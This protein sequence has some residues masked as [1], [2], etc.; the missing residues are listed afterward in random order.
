MKKGGHTTEERERKSR[1]TW[2]GAWHLFLLFHVTCPHRDEVVEYHTRL[3]TN[4]LSLALGSKLCPSLSLESFLISYHACSSCSRKPH[5]GCYIYTLAPSELSGS[6][7]TTLKQQEVTKPS[8]YLYD[9][10]QCD[11]SSLSLA[12]GTGKLPQKCT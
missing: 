8:L 10:L 12:G 11:F 6:A 5:G 7:P 2:C 4:P 3:R 9:S 1:T